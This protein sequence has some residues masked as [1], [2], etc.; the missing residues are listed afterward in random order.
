MLTCEIYLYDQ[1]TVQDGGKQRFRLHY[2]NQA[3]I[4]VV[5]YSGAYNV[6]FYGGAFVW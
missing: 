6:A 5:S 3:Y 4:Q 2:R 1:L